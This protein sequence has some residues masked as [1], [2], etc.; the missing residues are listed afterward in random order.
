MS[1]DDYISKLFIKNQDKLNQAPS[2]DFWSKLEAQLDETMPVVNKGQ[3]RAIGFSRYLAAASVI[4]AVMAS[5]YMVQVVTMQSDDL[6]MNMEMIEEPYPILTDAEPLED[7]VV[8]PT[9]V[10]ES[11][12]E[13]EVHEQEAKILEFVKK[14]VV[15]NKAIAQTTA[16][17]I[18]IGE[19]EIVDAAKE[20][21][22]DEG[23]S[24]ILIEPEP[25]VVPANTT[26][27]VQNTATNLYQNN[28][29]V[30]Q[31]RNYYNNQVAINLEDNNRMADKV[32]QKSSA[33]TKSKMARAKG[34]S[35]KGIISKPSSKAKKYK[36][37]MAT[38]HPRLQPFGF[39]LGKWVDD[40]E[41]E[42][43]SHE[44]WTLKDA[45]MLVGKGYKLN[46][47]ERIFE[48]MMRIEFRHNQVFLVISLDEDNHTIDY[49]MTE[50]DTERYVFRQSD[51]NDYP[52][53]VVI[54]RNLDGYSVIILNNNS[55]LSADQQR[56]L[57]NRNRVSHGRSVR[58]MRYED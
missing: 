21:E 3:T 28:I 55:F 6:A 53:K 22:L 45:N 38:A 18:E 50:F 24:I 29:P 30:Q 44:Y 36:S 9:R 34:T 56:Y 8:M 41:M 2:D 47:N 54:Q 5:V 49:M 52:D 23:N 4:F 26:T 27:T 51:S 39:L 1:R 16:A 12:D 33:S 7:D 48:E 25:E 20:D 58:T 57:E 10:L 11:V 17:G 15:E 14:D 31:N 13:E 37:P 43:K 42:G 32:S 19:I 46:G 40:N 35:R